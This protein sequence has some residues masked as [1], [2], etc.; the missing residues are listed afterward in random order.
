[1]PVTSGDVE[2]VFDPTAKQIEDKELLQVWPNPMRLL[3]IQGFKGRIRKAV[4]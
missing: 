2:Q 4:R 1:M 3:F